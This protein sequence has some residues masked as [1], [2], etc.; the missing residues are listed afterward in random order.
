MWNFVVLGKF[1]RIQEKLLKVCRGVQVSVLTQKSK[2]VNSVLLQL[3]LSNEIIFT[4]PLIF[5][6]YNKQIQQTRLL[7]KIYLLLFYP[8][9]FFL[10]LLICLDCAQ[11]TKGFEIQM[12]KWPHLEQDVCHTV[13]PTQ[14]ET[15]KS[16]QLL[17]STNCDGRS[18]IFILFIK[19]SL[20]TQQ[21]GN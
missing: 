13:I 2:I 19:C 21:T 7:I 18:E 10:Y 4:V 8:F 16:F 6:T 9:L 14:H 15:K 1:V 20:Q 17:H 5:D 11:F 3:N 12:S